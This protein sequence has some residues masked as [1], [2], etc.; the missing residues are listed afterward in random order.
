MANSMTHSAGKS[1]SGATSGLM[2]FWRTNFNM[3]VP[4]LEG[5]WSLGSAATSF[6]LT[7]FVP[8]LEICVGGLFA[9]IYGA[10][11][12][13]V[14]FTFG[15][16]NPAGECINA[17]GV[18]YTYT[19][20]VN[21]AAG[22]VW[23]NWFVYAANIGCASWEVASSGTYTLRSTMSGAATAPDASTNITFSNV[24]SVATTGTPGMIYV[25]GNYL[26][27]IN[28]NNFLH[29][30][31]GTDI[32]NPGA[33]PGHIWIDTSNNLSFIS[34]DGHKRTM[35][36]KIKQFASAFGNGATGEVSGKSPGYIYMDSEFGW[37]HIAYIGYDGYKYL[38]GAGDYPY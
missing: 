30:A 19:V 13:N 35:P 17:G 28:A 24:P 37:T 38:V 25:D 9:T 31:L 12:G 2:I 20:Y 36:W 8:G 7:G 26:A 14:T 18:P 16:Y 32:S 3:P 6:D 1:I 34:S 10:V 22:D 23:S 4:A 27:M 5:S 33:T 11:N 29:K 21:I 15:W